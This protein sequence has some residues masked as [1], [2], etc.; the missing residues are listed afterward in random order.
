MDITLILGICL[1]PIN[2]DDPAIPII[3]NLPKKSWKLFFVKIFGLKHTYIKE[4]VKL[5]YYLLNNVEYFDNWKYLGYME[6]TNEN[7]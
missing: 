3:S 4:N 6:K 7:C 2:K 1:G 5:T